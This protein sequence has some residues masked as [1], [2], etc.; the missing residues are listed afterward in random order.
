MTANNPGDWAATS[1]MKISL[2]LSKGQVMNPTSSINAGI[3]ILYIKGLTSDASGNLE[4]RNETGDWGTAVDRYNGGG[5]ANYQ[6]Q[7]MKKYNS[8]FV[9]T[10]A[11]YVMPRDSKAEVQQAYEQQPQGRGISQCE[12]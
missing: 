9:G 5:V 4:W 12:D 8:A 7:V 1:D 11:N 10:A 6:Q 3:D 2:G